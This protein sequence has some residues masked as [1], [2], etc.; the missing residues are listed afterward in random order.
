MATTKK[1]PATI[2]AI[3]AKT[4]PV[5]PAKA[6]AAPA[7]KKAVAKKVVAKVDAVKVAPVVAAAPAK[8]P[9]K[10]AAKAPAVAKPKAAAKKT[11]KVEGPAVD[12]A[13]RANYI[14]VA[15]YYI[16]QRRGFTPGDPEQDYLNAAA[17]VD[18]LIAAGH[19][20]K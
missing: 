11:G 19:F 13:Q 9:A 15:A 2:P 12:Q 14:E 6:V 5:A 8:P 17:E 20:S 4:A 16:A 3:P 10:S 18:Q 7:A 1:K